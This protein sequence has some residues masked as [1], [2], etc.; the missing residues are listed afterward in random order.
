MSVIPGWCASTRPGI[1]S[2]SG[3]LLRTRVRYY[4][5]PR[6]DGLLRL[7]D[8]RAG[9]ATALQVEMCFRRILERIGVVDRHMKLAADNRGKQRV[10]ALEQFLA[11]A[12]VII[13]LGPGRKQRAV[14]VELGNR[15]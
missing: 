6:N 13:E 9:G 4:A 8:R 11:G 1:S 10:G 12:D 5:S 14:I 2:F 7:Q 15:K 3:A